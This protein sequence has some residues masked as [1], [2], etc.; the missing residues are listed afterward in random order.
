LVAVSRA[1]L[2]AV[3]LA[4]A[5]GASDLFQTPVLVPILLAF[6]VLPAAAAWLVE[7]AAGARAAVRDDAL[8]LCRPHLPPAPAPT[9]IP[10]ASAPTCGGG[11]PAPGSRG[12]SPG[13]CPCRGPVSRS[14]CAP[15]GDCGTASKWRIPFRCWRCWGSR[16]A[17]DIPSSS[18][19]THVR[20]RR[21]G[22]GVT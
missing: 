3:G 6:S 22:G 2:V 17:Q 10:P 8:V 19:P 5:L 13:S 12:S 16:P 9:P 20:R 18:G 1:S 11:S 15:D 4:G 14:R 7:H 21:S